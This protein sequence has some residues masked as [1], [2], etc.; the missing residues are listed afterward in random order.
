MFAYKRRVTFYET[1]GMQVVHHANYLRF[2]E[3]ARVE[4]FRA[5]GLEL[6]DL[7]EEGIVFPIVE[8]SVKYHKPA[9]YDDIL[10]VKAYLRRLDRARFDFDY[11]IINEKT[12]DLL[13]TGHTVNTYT[14]R[15]TGRIVRL[16][17]ERLEKLFELSEEDRKN[18]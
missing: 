5:G 4:Y 8:V 15:K 10:V 1:D 16:P 6:N 12:G 18:G 13:I 11:E 7:M 14:D 9:R 2:M 3:E 17:K